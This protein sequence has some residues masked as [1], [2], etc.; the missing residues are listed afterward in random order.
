MKTL[1]EHIVGGLKIG[2]KTKVNTYN[3][4]PKDRKELKNLVNKLIKERG[5]NTDLND[6]NT[7]EIT[8]MHTLFIYSP[9]NG[10]ISNWDVSNVEDM[11]YMFYDSPL[12]KNPPKWYKK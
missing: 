10:D 12:Q 8:D 4:H 7:S 3:Y 1:K 5:N 11:L 9:F 6:I 2:A